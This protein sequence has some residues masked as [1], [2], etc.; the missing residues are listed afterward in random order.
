MAQSSGSPQE[1]DGSFG[2]PNL[3]EAYPGFVG[4][5]EAEA[6]A[7]ARKSGRDYPDDT[8]ARSDADIPDTPLADRIRDAEGG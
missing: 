8:A 4:G 5:A 7:S 6:A 1:R 3:Q 2:S